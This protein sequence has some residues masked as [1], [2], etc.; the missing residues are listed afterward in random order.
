MVILFYL[1][2]LRRIDWQRGGRGAVRTPLLLLV[3]RGSELLIGEL[4]DIKIHKF[5]H[6]VIRAISTPS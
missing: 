6:S 1:L 2:I 4:P 3:E 5:Y